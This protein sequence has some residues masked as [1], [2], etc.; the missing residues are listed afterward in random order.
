M[1]SSIEVQHK[2]LDRMSTEE[3]STRIQ[4]S[5]REI[6]ILLEQLFTR[7]QVQGYTEQ[8]YDELL[9]LLQEAMAFIEA[10]P[11]DERR[12]LEWTERRSALLEKLNRKI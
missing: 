2:Q 8:Q 6:D 11:V 12:L 10:V 1:S 3:I 9:V 7:A 4:Q 5:Q